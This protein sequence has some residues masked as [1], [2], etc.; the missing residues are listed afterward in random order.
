MREKRL[1]YVN[2]YTDR[3][4]KRRIYL[5]R[6]GHPRIALPGPYKSEAFWKA[7]HAAMDATEQAE[8]TTRNAPG[9]IGAAIVGYYASTEFRALASSTQAVYRGI[10]ERF[11]EKHGDGP[12]ATIK[13][14]HVN[15]LIDEMADTP[16]AASNFRKRL[17][18]VFDYAVGAGLRTD[19]PVRAAKKPKIK[20]DG[21]RTWTE[22]DIAAYRARW[23]EDTPQRVAMEI[24]LHT[25][26]RRSDAVRIGWANLHDDLIVVKAKKTGAELHIPVHAD[27]RRFIQKCPRSAATFISKGN[28]K[29]RSEKAFS[30]YISGAAAKAGLPE[31][32]SPHGLRK[33]ACRR[34]AEAGCSAL[35]IMSIT[36]H[37]DIREVERYCREAQ[38]K[39]LARSAMDKSAK[40][41]DT[42]L[43]NGNPVSQNTEDNTLENNG[44]IREWRSRQDSNLRPSA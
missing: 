20:T 6:P 35:E 41:F 16:A 33:A 10:L 3:T 24:L 12:I 43:T 26:L 11:R 13:T 37:T 42:E 27:L 29:A 39:L 25:G 15:N 40:A 32:S 34:L 21:H 14:H 31:G 22:H 19:N 30:A 4:G 36:G 2:V 1:K 28:E 38:R 18:G 5:R 8:K 7:Y 17:I 9:T 44:E 23:P